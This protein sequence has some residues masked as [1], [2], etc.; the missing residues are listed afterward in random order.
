MIIDKFAE[1][2]D[3]QMKRALIPSLYGRGFCLYEKKDAYEYLSKIHILFL[4]NSH[5]SQK[6][7]NKHKYIK[8]NVMKYYLRFI[9]DDESKLKFTG[10]MVNTL[11]KSVFRKTID[12]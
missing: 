11:L 4:Q 9:K 1:D 12:E 7:E 6:Q 3:D 10:Y 2:I 8:Q 5:N